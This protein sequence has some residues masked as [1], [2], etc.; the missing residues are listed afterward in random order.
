MAFILIEHG[1]TNMENMN[2]LEKLKKLLYYWIEHND[3]D[4]QIYWDWAE[5]VSSFGNKELTKVLIGLS[6]ETK[7]LNRLFEEAIKMIG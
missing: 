4:A 2:E 6:D 7:K 5:K 3:R 1:E